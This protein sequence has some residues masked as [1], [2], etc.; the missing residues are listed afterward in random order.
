MAK[1]VNKVIL[2]G[3]VGK[4]PE[5]RNTRNGIVTELSL[6]TNHCGRN[7]ILTKCGRRNQT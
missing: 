6:A 4:S 7:S 1:C 2:L 3:N 5:I